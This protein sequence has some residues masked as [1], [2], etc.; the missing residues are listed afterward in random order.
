MLEGGTALQP[1]EDDLERTE[2]LP[3]QQEDA[4]RP[5]PNEDHKGKLFGFRTVHETSY[6]NLLDI[7]HIGIYFPSCVI[8]NLL[9]IKWQ[10]TCFVQNK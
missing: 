9:D 2:D 7:K 8:Y 1:G 10:R 6:F 4:N 3:H 5:Q